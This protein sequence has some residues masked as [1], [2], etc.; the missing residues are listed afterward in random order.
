MTY[1]YVIIGGGI[2]GIA[3]ARLLQLAGVERLLVLEAATELGG[4]C[5]TREINGHVLDIGGGHFLCSRY[6]EVYDFIFRHIARSEF[7]YFERVSRVMLEGQEVDYPVEANLWQLPRRKCREYLV[8]IARNGEARGMPPPANFEDWVRW[9]FGDRIA[10]QCM[11]PYNRKIWGVP[12]REMDVNWL[13]K[14]PRLPVREVIAACIARSAG[15]SH[16]P[17]HAGFYYPKRG[18]YQRVFDALADPVR[19]LVQARTPVSVIERVGDTLVLDGR[20]RARTV[21]NTAPWNTLLESPLL[22]G[23]ARDAVA[24]LRHNEIVVSLHENVCQT[25][26]HWLYEPD[27][28]LAHHRTFFVPNFAPHSVANGFFRETN[29]QRWTSGRGEMFAEHNA[30]A[31]P[32]PTLGR[33]AAIRTVLE[34]AVQHQVYGLGRWGQWQYVNSDVCIRE[35]MD[36]VDRLGHRSWR[37]ALAG[38]VAT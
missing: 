1:N 21:I 27:E 32:I 34:E 2:T 26:A 23:A 20:I 19:G 33:A 4:L 14:I 22:R 15:R 11:L 30:Y 8:S 28:N 7:N 10:E 29:R 6:P 17:S 36:L 13:H 18:G 25:N 37:N 31:Y 16:L 35:A 5:R 12:V 24:R 38:A 9:K 3:V